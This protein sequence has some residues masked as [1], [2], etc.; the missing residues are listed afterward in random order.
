M[1]G[2]YVS[3]TIS[4]AWLFLTFLLH[5]V[6]QMNSDSF[7]QLPPPPLFR[8]QSHWVLSNQKSFFGFWEFAHFLKLCVKMLALALSRYIWGSFLLIWPPANIQESAGHLK[9]TQ[10][11]MIVEPIHP[12]RGKDSCGY[13]FQGGREDIHTWTVRDTNHMSKRNLTESKMPTVLGL[14]YREGLWGRSGGRWHCFTPV[15]QFS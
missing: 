3:L 10:S 2:A 14:C 7:C 6:F 4:S 11:S 13:G 12:E 1:G 9:Y 5:S 8:L 15:R